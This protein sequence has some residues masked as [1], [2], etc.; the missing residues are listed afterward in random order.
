MCKLFT[1]DRVGRKTIVNMTINARRNFY[2]G[3]VKKRE[4]YD[5][6][7]I[8]RRRE[9]SYESLENIIYQENINSR[10]H[11]DVSIQRRL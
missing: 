3:I 10:S 9:A 4:R 2:I 11:T 6:F 7:E 1:I 8:R 5:A